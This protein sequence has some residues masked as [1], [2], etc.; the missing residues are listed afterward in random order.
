MKLGIQVG[1]F[2]IILTNPKIEANKKHSKVS[3]YFDFDNYKDNFLLK[4]KRNKKI[5]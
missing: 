1:K 2:R 4:S 3:L 5:T